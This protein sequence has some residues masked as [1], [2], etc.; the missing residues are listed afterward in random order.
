M[1]GQSQA[2]TLFAAL[3]TVHIG[4][5]TPFVLHAQTQNDNVT[6]CIFADYFIAEKLISLSNNLLLT[7]PMED[8]L[9]IKL[10]VHGYH[11]RSDIWEAAVR[12]ELCVNVSPGAR[13][14]VIP[15]CGR[16]FT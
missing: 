16:E 3:S 10:C 4:V 7:T 15:S 13:K 8:E 14:T 1:F 6:R 5:T 2:V 11:V 9:A 12:K